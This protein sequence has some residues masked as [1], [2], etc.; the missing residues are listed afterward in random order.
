MGMTSAEKMRAKRA[1]DAAAKADPAEDAPARASAPI[2]K[3]SSDK[4]IDALRARAEKGDVPAARELRE[5]IEHRKQDE[6]RERDQRVLALLSP[7]QIDI[8]AG[9]IYGEELPPSWWHQ[10]LT[11]APA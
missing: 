2:E 9:W 8:V 11:V 10:R 1:R 5:W 6:G 7:E 4:I 3:A